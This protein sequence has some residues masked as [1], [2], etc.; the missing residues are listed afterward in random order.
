M[1]L[2]TSPSKLLT[3]EKDISYHIFSGTISS[4]PRLTRPTHLSPSLAVS[5]AGVP[6]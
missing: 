1:D 5:G 6:I 2:E 3:A 4:H